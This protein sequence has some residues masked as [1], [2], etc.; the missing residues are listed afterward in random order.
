M[1]IIEEAMVVASARSN[2]DKVFLK[3]LRWTQILLGLDYDLSLEDNSGDAI[4]S[5]VEGWEINY[6][7]RSFKLYFPES[8][9]FSGVNYDNVGPGFGPIMDESL[10]K[11]AS[12]QKRRTPRYEN[13]DQEIT[14]GAVYRRKMPQLV[15]FSRA[16]HPEMMLSSARNFT[17]CKKLISKGDDINKSCS[18]GRT[19]ILNSLESLDMTVFGNVKPDERFFNYFKDCGVSVDAINRVTE[20]ERL[21]PLISAIGTGRVDIVES[22][23]TLGARPNTCLLY[24]SPSPRDA[25]LS[26]MPSSA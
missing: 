13:R 26:R 9:L 8:V 1:Q 20:L 16:S 21:S 23:L 15:W 4:F 22:V 25:T 7:R 11:R 10:L 19:P 24:T 2:P 5:V 14:V 17:F 18:D 12:S 3:W 6:L